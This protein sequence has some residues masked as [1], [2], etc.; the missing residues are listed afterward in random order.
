MTIADTLVFKLTGAEWITSDTHFF[1]HKNIIAYTGRPFSNITEMREKL[2]YNWNSVVNFN[3]IIFV[4]GDFAFGGTQAKKELLTRLNGYKILIKGNHDSGRNKMA[5]VGFHDACKTAEGTIGEK[6]FQMIHV[7]LVSVAKRFDVLL[8]GHVHERWVY[9]A[10][11]IFNVGCDQW[12]F[13]PQTI[14]YI[15]ANAA[16]RQKKLPYQLSIMTARTERDEE[17]AMDMYGVKK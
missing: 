2:I 14:N 10:P 13:K 16:E 3:D 6:T 15:L 12:D 7:P 17:V 4:L 1:F 11:N 9:S 8:C 5:S